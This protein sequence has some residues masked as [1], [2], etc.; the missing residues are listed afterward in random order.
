MSVVRHSVSQWRQFATGRL[1][2]AI[3]NF[4][5]VHC[6][7]QAI[8][9]RTAQLAQRLGHTAAVL[10]FDPHPLKVLRSPTT[11]LLLTTLEQRLELFAACGVETVIVQPFDEA[12]ARLSPEEFVEQVLVA[13][14]RVAA[15]VV[16]Q[17]FRFGH[18][19]TGRTDTLIEWGRRCGFCVEVVPPVFVRGHLVS[20][21]R[22]RQALAEGQVGLAGR[23]LGRP[24]SLT[25]WIEPGTGRGSQLLVPTLNLRP[26]QEILPRAGVYATETRVGSQWFRSATNVGFRPTFDGQQLTVESHLLDFGQALHEGRLEIRFWKRLR[27]EQR[28]A[29]AAA[30]REQIQLDLDR[31]RRFFARLDRWRRSTRRAV[32]V[33]P[34]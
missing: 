30:L 15:V 32:C 11:P 28:F 17:N 19:Q 23:L 25:G 7:H 33:N 9:H 29:S 18:Q 8:L 12:F 13:A 10:T 14:L 6:G 34:S 26:E 1:V 3:G 2:C 22:V 20:S 24:F 31:T 16:G 21:T 5:G 27:D 4:D